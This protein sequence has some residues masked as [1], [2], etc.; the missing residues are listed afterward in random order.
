MLE[1]G[2][3]LLQGA[4]SPQLQEIAREFMRRRSR[5]TLALA[6]L[7]RTSGSSYLLP[8]ARMLITQGG[9]TFGLLSGGCIEEE[10]AA[11]ARDVM[12]TGT[13]CLLTFDTRPHFGC[14]GALY[15]F[16]ERIS[17]EN[18]FLHRLDRCIR[19]RVAFVAVTSF[20]RTHL[21]LGGESTALADDHELVTGESPTALLQRVEPPLQLVIAGGGRDDVPL[22]KMA[23]GLGWQVLIAS[24]PHDISAD[25]RTVAVVKTHNYGRD[26]A[27]LRALLPLD[28]PYIG[29]IGSRKR[30]EQLV[31]ALLDLGERLERTMVIHGPAGLDVGAETP[32]EIALSVIAEIQAVLAN[33]QHHSLRDRR[34]PA[35]YARTNCVGSAEA[36]AK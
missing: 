12:R 8:G 9:E 7:V 19:E 29:L 24:E 25:A 16:V 18:A 32:E 10:V 4:V 15:I 30:K 21:D 5:E 36:A 27:F 13:P 2:A 6:T 26:F 31:G 14:S 35:R 3:P 23:R 28:L 1:C 20:E 11:K 17:T 33:R 22:V 34:G